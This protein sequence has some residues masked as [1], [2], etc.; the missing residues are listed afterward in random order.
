MGGMGASL[1]GL[2]REK[3]FSEKFLFPES[4]PLSKLICSSRR[5]MP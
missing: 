5:V 4:S 3:F 2:E 1:A